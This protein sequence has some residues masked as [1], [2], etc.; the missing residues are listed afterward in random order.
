MSNVR[1][2][3]IFVTNERLFLGKAVGENNN[4]MITLMLDHE[5]MDSSDRV[6]FVGQIL[7]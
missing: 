2:V 6:S 7:H 1:G 5:I 3:F 4:L